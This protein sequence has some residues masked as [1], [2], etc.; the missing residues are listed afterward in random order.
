LRRICFGRVEI[1]GQQRFDFDLFA[2]H[3]LQQRHSFADDIIEIDIARCEYLPA[4]IGQ[5]LPCLA[6]CAFRLFTNLHEKFVCTASL[7]HFFFAQFGPT[8]NRAD[9]VIKIMGDAPR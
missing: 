6:A 1:R 5:Q 8:H 2:D 9:Y 4:C 7:S 3:S